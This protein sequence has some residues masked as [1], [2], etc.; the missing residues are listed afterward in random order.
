MDFIFYH[1]RKKAHMIGLLD[2]I[3]LVQC[4][5]TAEILRPFDISNEDIKNPKN[6]AI[7]KNVMLLYIEISISYVV[8]LLVTE[9]YKIPQLPL[10][11]MKYLTYALNRK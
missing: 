10:A 6:R 5:S 3:A 7:E 8:I 2:R 4:F 11:I 9:F 1:K